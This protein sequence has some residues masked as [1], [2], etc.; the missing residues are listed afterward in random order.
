MDVPSPPP[1]A[2]LGVVSSTL[3]VARWLTL[4]L[5]LAIPGCY[6][7]HPGRELDPWSRGGD[8]DSDDGVLDD[9]GDSASTNDDEGEGEGASSTTGAGDDDGAGDGNPG[10]ADDGGIDDGGADDG[11]SD[12]GGADD[13]GG[14]S[15]PGDDVPGSAYCDDAADWTQSWATLEDE[16]LTLV[17]QR[18]SEGANCGTEGSFNPAPPLTMNPALRCA[19]RNHSKDMAVNDFFSHTNLQNQSPFERM[20][21]AGY[22]YSAAGENIAAGNATAAATM[23]QWMSSDGHCA[24]I[25]NPSFQELGV[26]YHPGGSYGHYWTQKF[27]RP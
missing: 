27:G 19:S 4:L 13:G 25:M 20:Q 2:S 11:G 12:D 23:Q 5:P 15:D 16:I 8:T 21:L 9:E 17:N 26:G 18:R 10:G 24:N 3:R 6:S 7:G 22:S 1:P 14:P